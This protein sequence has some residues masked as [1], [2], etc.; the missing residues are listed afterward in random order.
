MK[1]LTIWFS[2]LGL[3]LAVSAAHAQDIR[4]EG[5]YPIRFR[6]GK[7]DAAGWRVPCNS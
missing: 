7:S 6:R 4:R 1:S 2:F 3:L 5:Q